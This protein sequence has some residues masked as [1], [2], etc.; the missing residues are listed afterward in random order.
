MSRKAR[1][2]VC[3]L[4]E[5][6]NREKRLTFFQFFHTLKRDPEVVVV[7]PSCRVVQELDV[8]DIDDGLGSEEV[9]V[10]GGERRESRRHELT[11][12]MLSRWCAGSVDAW[13]TKASD[14]GGDEPGV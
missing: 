7:F 2:I 1:C 12:V 13:A 5:W 10:S 11:I 3:R 9:S 4:L 14:G 8:A 6:T